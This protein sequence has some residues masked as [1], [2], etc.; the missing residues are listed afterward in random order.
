MLE[1]WKL[2]LLNYYLL[3]LRVDLIEGNLVEAENI[4]IM[5]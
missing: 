1:W 2:A 5:V 3:K 4:L